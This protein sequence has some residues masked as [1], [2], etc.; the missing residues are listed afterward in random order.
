MNAVWTI[1]G[2]WIAAAA[3]AGAEV[4]DGTIEGAGIVL[5]LEGAPE[6]WSP[7]EAEFPR[8][9]VSFVSL[10]EPLP[11]LCAAEELV[12]VVI[13]MG[14]PATGEGADVFIIGVGVGGVVMMGIVR[15]PGPSSGS[16]PDRL[17]GICSVAV[18]IGSTMVQVISMVEN[19]VET[20][21][22]EEARKVQSVGDDMQ[23]GETR[24]Y[25]ERGIG[26]GTGRGTGTDIDGRQV[27]TKDG[28]AS[29]VRQGHDK[30]Q[31][32]TTRT[33]TSRKLVFEGMTN[34]IASTSLPLDVLGGRDRLGYYYTLSPIRATKDSSFKGRAAMRGRRHAP[35]A[36]VLSWVA[37]RLL[38]PR[39]LLLLRLRLL[40]C[41][42]LFLFLFLFLVMLPTAADKTWGI[43]LALG[44]AMTAAASKQVSLAQA[45]ADW[46][47]QIQ[48]EE[49][50]CRNTAQRTLTVAA[51]AAVGCCVF[52]DDVDALMR[53]QCYA[54][55]SVQRQLCKGKERRQ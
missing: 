34:R 1:L 9:F 54:R 46:W 49:D 15:R 26:T 4:D 21:D 32:E 6:F 42:F 53:T 27:C 12:G 31:L 14:S 45:A 23:R 55:R 29:E 38:F 17:L 28:A 30:T 5:L 22:K 33:A 8:P 47:L 36:D 13:S 20:R 19:S 41:L 44:W 37:F 40:L 48:I 43:P 3:A 50:R 10:S 11:M 2:W 18:A 25:K 16:R 24:V 39:L 52:W 51:V 35:A 7:H